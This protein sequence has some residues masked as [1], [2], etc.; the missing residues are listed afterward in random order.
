M[1]ISEFINLIRVRILL[2]KG[3]TQASEEAADD[4][5][6][7]KSVRWD[8]ERTLLGA[9]LIF[10]VSSIVTSMIGNTTSFD[11]T[12][13]W[14]YVLTRILYSLGPSIKLS[15]ASRLIVFLINGIALGTCAFRSLQSYISL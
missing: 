11:L 13:G 5:V 9:P 6:F 7:A 4:L 10:Y 14:V 2:E 15:A 3:I 12:A 8:V 1:T